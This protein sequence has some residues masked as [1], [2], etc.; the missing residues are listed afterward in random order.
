MGAVFVS[1]RR[2]DAEGQARALFND[3]SDLI[4]RDSVFM[5][6][7]SIA[8]GRDFRQILQERLGSCEPLLALIGPRHQRRVRKAPL[9]KSN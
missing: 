6:V 5:D 3:L 9:G 4:G 2:G 7:D 8:L 1:Y